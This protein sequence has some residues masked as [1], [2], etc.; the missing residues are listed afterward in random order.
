MRVNE[1]GNDGLSA[2]VNLD[3]ARVGEPAHFLIRPD[4]EEAPAG[5]GHCL[6]ARL[7]SVNGDDVAV[8]EDRLRRVVFESD[9]GK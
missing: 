4:R 3:G 5:D 7:T 8:V 9:N 1:A 2:E 6:R